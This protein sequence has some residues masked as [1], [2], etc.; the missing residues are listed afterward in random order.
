MAN[1]LFYLQK[2]TIPRQI[3]PFLAEI[4]FNIL[5]LRTLE[6]SIYFDRLDY[7]DFIFG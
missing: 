7:K 4:R 2:I 1:N 3:I 5:K 6:K